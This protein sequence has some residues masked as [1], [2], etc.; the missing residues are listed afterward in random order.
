MG[1][2]IIPS[3]KV[4]RGFLNE[5]EEGK[6]HVK[7]TPYLVTREAS[8]RLKVTDEKGQVVGDGELKKNEK[9]KTDRSPDHVGFI[10]IHVD[11]YEI[12]GYDQRSIGLSVFEEQTPA[13]G[14][15]A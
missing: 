13:Q 11:E 4:G 1:I 9:K 6:I 7:D 12:I 10:R 15:A 14:G 3:T 2:Q 5:N 8:G